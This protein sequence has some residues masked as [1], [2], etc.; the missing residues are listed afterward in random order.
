MAS[1]VRLSLLGHLAAL[2][3]LLASAAAA[4]HVPLHGREHHR[5]MASAQHIGGEV[6]TVKALVAVMVSTGRYCLP[7][8]QSAGH[9]GDTAPIR[10]SPELFIR[11]TKVMTLAACLR[12]LALDGS[13]QRGETTCDRHGFQ[14]LRRNLTG[15]RCT[16]QS[17]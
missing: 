2:L 7:Q 13:T 4:K 6:R 8:Q 17:K 15:K 16:T 3:L 11:V 14:Q 1:H 12:R 10:T 9:S 5:K